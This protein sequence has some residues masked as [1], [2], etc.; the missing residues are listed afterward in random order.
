MVY[1]L[2]AFC[3]KRNSFS[4]YL[5]TLRLLL[6]KSWSN[7]KKIAAKNGMLLNNPNIRGGRV[8]INAWLKLL[9]HLMGGGGEE[10]R[11]N[12][13][14]DLRNALATTLST[15]FLDKKIPAPH[16]AI[17]F[18]NHNSLYSNSFPLIILTDSPLNLVFCSQKTLQICK[19][20][21]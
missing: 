3:A 2:L 18:S 8:F 4:H 19:L 7:M 13:Y 21:F 14:T 16:N 11:S 20:T 12:Y 9:K 5:H 6:N 15:H 1:I 10:E 17:S